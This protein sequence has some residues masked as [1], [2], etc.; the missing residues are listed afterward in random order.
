MADNKLTVSGKHILITGGAGFIGSHLVDRLATGNKITVVDNLSA[1]KLEFI[2]QH[3]DKPEEEFRFV[4]LDILKC[5]DHPELFEGVDVIFHLAAN[6]DVRV[7]ETDTYIHFEQNILASYYLLEMAREHKVSEF[8]FTSSSVVYGE[9]KEIPTPENYGPLIPI[10]L[11]GSSK[12]SAEAFISAFAHN[13]NIRSTIYRFANV[14]GPKSTHGVTFDFLNKLKAN[15]LEL[16]ILGDGRQTKSYFYIDD[17]I[18]GMVAG[19][20]KGEELVNIFNIGSADYIDVTTIA[21]LVCKEMGLMDVKYSYTGGVDG[22]AGWKGDVKI[23]LLGIEKLR[24][25]GW[26]SKHSSSE[27]IALT[28]RHLLGKA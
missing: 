3:L 18:E 24:K 1:G 15:P 23:M 19:W 7:G 2:Q 27:S 10:S 26:E 25:L 14:V 6:P 13:F 12:L 16:V 9:A 28:A 22:G 5:R 21:N 4:K 17:C 11:Y 20:L 8:I